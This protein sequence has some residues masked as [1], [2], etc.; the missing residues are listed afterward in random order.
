MQLFFMLLIKKATTNETD[1]CT[2]VSDCSSATVSSTAVQ[3]LQPQEV[4]PT[5]RYKRHSCI[6]CAKLVKTIGRHL[7]KM[8]SN[9]KEIQEL[10]AMEKAE[11][12][13]AIRRLRLKGDMEY[14][15]RN[16]DK[17]F[18][19]EPKLPKNREIGVACTSCGGWFGRQDYARHNK[20]CT[21]RVSYRKHV[22]KEAN[23]ALQKKDNIPVLPSY[24]EEFLSTL[25]NDN[26]RTII[27]KD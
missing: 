15:K 18:V 21:G 27:K 23:K 11:K 22:L 24:T 1:V 16:D 20:R 7:T 13:R 2:T 5:K 26:I 8:H 19:R 12:Y 25:A 14:N 6:F 10:N 9:E 3:S 17:I 4:K